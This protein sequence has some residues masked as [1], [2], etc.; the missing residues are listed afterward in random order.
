MFVVTYL[1]FYYPYYEIMM[2]NTSYF[3]NFYFYFVQNFD[4]KQ[5]Y[6]AQ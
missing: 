4:D 2:F 1:I 3:F 6:M 5:A